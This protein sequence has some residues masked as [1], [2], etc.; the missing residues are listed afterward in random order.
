M[1]REHVVTVTLKDCDVQTFCAGG[2]GGSNQNA[3][4]TGVRI[5]HR[6]SNAVGEARDSRYQWQNKKAAFRRMS[7][8]LK[9]KQ[10][11]RR[12]AGLDEELP[13][14]R[15]SAY[16]RTYNLVDKRVKDH[17]TGEASANVEAVLNGEL[18]VLT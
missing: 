14:H 9:F 1:T 6:A 12:I 8:S 5:I 11:V 4:Q 2:N 18:D 13:D 10:W 7:E 15:S 17:R 3:K 16:V